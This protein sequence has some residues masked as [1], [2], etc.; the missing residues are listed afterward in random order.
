MQKSHEK[1]KKHHK[2]TVAIVSDLLTRK[3]EFV[4]LFGSSLWRWDS[5]ELQVADRDADGVAA[6]IHQML[7][8]NKGIDLNYVPP[9][10]DKTG[11]ILV[12][13][14]LLPWFSMVGLE[15]KC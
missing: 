4:L 12:L 7:T 3:A 2:R 15:R 1:E 5:F 13:A 10:R 9:K 6:T 8:G 11:K 14:K